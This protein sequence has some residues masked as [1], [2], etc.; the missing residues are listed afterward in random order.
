M[1]SESQSILK[2]NQNNESNIYYYDKLNLK[3]S[4]NYSI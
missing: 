1:D 3:S 2:S 4:K